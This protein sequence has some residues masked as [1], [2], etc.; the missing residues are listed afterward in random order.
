MTEFV[1]SLDEQDTDFYSRIA[2]IKVKTMTPMYKTTGQDKNDA[3][4]VVKAER[5][6]FG[7]LLV[8]R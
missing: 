4:T 5:D 2:Q 3:V 8:V 1:K 6:I 7:R